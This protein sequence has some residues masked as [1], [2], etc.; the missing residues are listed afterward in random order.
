M[1]VHEPIL[2]LD[3]NEGP[4]PP[5][6]W[7]QEK[8]SEVEVHRYPVYDALRSS[9]AE[10]HRLEPEQVVVGAGGDDV[11]ERVVRSARGLLTPKPA[12]GMFAFYAAAYQR[13][14]RMTSWPKNELAWAETFLS[15]RSEETDWVVVTSPNNPTGAW[16]SESVL[17]R[18]LEH[19]PPGVH[20]LLDQVY[21]EFGNDSLTSLALRHPRALVVRSFS[22]SFGLAGLRVGYGL[23]AT[24]LVE[25]LRRAGAPFPVAVPSAWLA[26]SMLTDPPQSVEAY[27]RFVPRA[28]DRMMAFLEGHGRVLPS[29]ANFVFLELDEPAELHQALLDAGIAVR[30]FEGRA[31]HEA[32]GLRITCPSSE[33]D[34]VRLESFFRARSG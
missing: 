19:L 14:L 23:G 32:R 17:Q 2:K 27:W 5:S 15:A 13:P 10:R 18:L 25:R 22:K 1:T 26:Q 30:L 3:M 4:P 28:R 21:A 33:P 34:L 11:I 24:E 12:F 7:L 16:I 31:E 29:M 20:L 6:S 9:I 8:L